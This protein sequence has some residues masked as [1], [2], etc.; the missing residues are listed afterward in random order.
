MTDEEGD[1]PCP[2]LDGERPDL[3]SDDRRS[4]W[5][6][7]DG[8]SVPVRHSSQWV[9]RGMAFNGAVLGDVNHHTG[10]SITFLLPHGRFQ[11]SGFS[12]APYAGLRRLLVLLT[13]TCGEA[14]DL[15]EQA[16]SDREAL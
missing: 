11:R 2:I 16:F 4:D 14:A 5:T 15:L 10:P 9:S 1:A 12:P 8:R 6:Q 7:N 13:R 3:G